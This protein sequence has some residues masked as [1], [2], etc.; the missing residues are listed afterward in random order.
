[1][2]DAIGLGGMK[3]PSRVKGLST[4]DAAAWVLV[5]SRRSASLNVRLKD[6]LGPVTRVKK[7]KKK[8]GVASAQLP[9]G[10][11]TSVSFI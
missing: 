5:K 6:L 10:V 4:R 11:R 2:K 8:I 9:G 1:V 3:E 7:K